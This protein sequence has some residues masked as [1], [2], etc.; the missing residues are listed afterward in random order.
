MGKWFLFIIVIIII[1]NL[2]EREKEILPTIPSPNAPNSTGTKTGSWEFS[3]GLP[4][5]WQGCRNLTH[6]CSVYINA[7]NWS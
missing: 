6:H 4:V 2:K 7:G 1:I 3:P 5:G